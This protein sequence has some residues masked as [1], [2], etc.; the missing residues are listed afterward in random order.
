MTIFSFDRAIVR[1]PAPSVVHGLRTGD[2]EG[3]SFDGVARE[4][5]AYVAALRRAGLEV[6]ILPPLPACPDS[7]FVEDPALVFTEGAILLRPGAP[8]R[9]NEAAALEVPLREMFD[10][11]VWLPDGHADGGDVLVTPGKVFIGLSSRTDEAGA[12]A[13]VEALAGLGR[14]A[15]IVTPPPGTLHLKSASSLIDEETVLATEALA[16]TGIFAGLRVLTVPTDEQGGANVLRLNDLVLAGSA[17]PRT[18]DLLAAHGLEPVPLD[19]H[20]I[21]KIDAGLTC[22]SLRWRSPGGAQP[23]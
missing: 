10:T 11:V 15:K 7:I 1:Q 12:T 2:H 5:A 3:P 6:T 18:L 21:A 22:M 13:L 19:V 20:E 23:L 4:H 8:T 9:A 16:A 17:Y 14:P